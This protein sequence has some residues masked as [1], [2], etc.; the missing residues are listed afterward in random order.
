MY[1]VNNET[2]HKFPVDKT[3]IASIHFSDYDVVK[4]RLK[5]KY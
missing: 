4:F 3:K 5:D 2:V 1:Y